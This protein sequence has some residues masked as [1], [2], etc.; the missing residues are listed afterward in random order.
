MKAKVISIVSAL[1]YALLLALQPAVGQEPQYSQ[2]G[3]QYFNQRLD[4]LRC[5]QDGLAIDGSLD[6]DGDWFAVASFADASGDRACGS[7]AISAGGGYRTAFDDTFD[8]YG[9]LSFETV[10]PDVGGSDSGLIIVGGMRGFIAQDIEGKLELAHHTVF[11]GSTTI[12]AGGAFWFNRQFAA[13]TD[14]TLSSNGTTFAIG[15][16]MNF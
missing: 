12:T 7:T 14:L 9:T 2:A 15:A 3:I 4:D 13:T 6:L 1:S 11:T 16:R 5:R 8:M 10:S